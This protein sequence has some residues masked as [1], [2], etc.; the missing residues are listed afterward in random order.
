[1]FCVFYGYGY[2][3]PV[4]LHFFFYKNKRIFLF[5]LIILCFFHNYLDW[6]T[7]RRTDVRQTEGWSLRLESDVPRKCDK[8]ICTTCLSLFSEMLFSTPNIPILK[9]DRSVPYYLFFRLNTNWSLAFTLISQHLI[10]NTK[11]NY[12][13]FI[14]SFL[15]QLLRK[16]F[17]F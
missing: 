15:L 5:V 11:N 12:L 7:D 6:D 10:T 16:Y 4:C 13:W 1:M 17:Q 2:L 3:Y 9:F 8:N 14:S